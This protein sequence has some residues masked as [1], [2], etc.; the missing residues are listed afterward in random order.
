MKFTRAGAGSRVH[1]GSLKQCWVEA[2]AHTHTDVAKNIP[3]CSAGDLHVPRVICRGD[4]A[5]YSSASPPGSRN[6]AACRRGTGLWLPW[7]QPAIM[8]H[9]GQPGDNRALGLHLSC[10]AKAARALLPGLPLPSPVQAD[11]PKLANRLLAS[12]HPMQLHH[13][14]T[15]L[16]YSIAWGA[17]PALLK[18]DCNHPRR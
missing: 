5:P 10:E 3:F 7:P 13:L 17:P 2:R 6:E 12:L 16:G 15:F 4:A 1:H 14:R 8:C 18:G 11:T 9:L